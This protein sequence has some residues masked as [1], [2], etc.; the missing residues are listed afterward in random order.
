[1]A[2]H[3]GNSLKNDMLCP[4]CKAPYNGKNTPHCLPCGHSI[5][6]NCVNKNTNY[7]NIFETTCK[8]CGY[9]CKIS[10]IPP[11]NRF[12]LK[13]VLI[14]NSSGFGV[15]RE[16]EQDIKAAEE[17]LRELSQ[18]IVEK[19]QELNEIKMGNSHLLTVL[20]EEKM[21]EII[22]K[23]QESKTKR[24][25]MLEE[26]ESKKRAMLKE[27]ESTK[28]I[29]EKA[30]QDEL[31]QFKSKLENVKRELKEY[32]FMQQAIKSEKLVFLKNYSKIVRSIVTFS[33]EISNVDIID[34]K[35]GKTSKGKI[36]KMITEIVGWNEKVGEFM[37]AMERFPHL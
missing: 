23:E 5:C 6:Y 15:S 3:F 11:V 1:M 7:R 21:I 14:E 19:H 12:H 13:Q 32:M 8:T 31:L 10:D 28:K 33:D 2:E 17:R 27:A 25:L 18:Q 35:S 30:Q 26:A 36:R 16:T 20:Y 29:A 4:E 22:T 24:K 34:K 9:E 37:G